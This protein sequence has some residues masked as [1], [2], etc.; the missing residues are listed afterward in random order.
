MDQP[1]RYE[2]LDGLGDALVAARALKPVPAKK[3]VDAIRAS[4]PEPDKKA[5]A[6]EPAV[7]RTIAK[8][9]AGRKKK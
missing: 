9:S 1:C 5:A 2:L 8:K 4:A 7:K 3:F 6:K